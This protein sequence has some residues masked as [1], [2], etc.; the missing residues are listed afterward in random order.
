MRKK[1]LE[2]RDAAPDRPLYYTEW[3]ISSNPRDPQH[4]SS[5][6]AA[7]AVRIAMSVDDVVDGYSWW[8]FSDIFE[9]NYF[10]S[11]P[12]HGGF[13]MMNLY[14]IP[15]PIYRAFELVRRLGDQQFGV[16]G[17][18]ATVNVWVGQASA[19][20]GARTLVLIVNQ[21]MPRHPIAAEPVSVRLA[22][23]DGRQVRSAV[24][25]RVDEDHAN[26]A[27]AWA[28][29]GSPEYLKPADV[30]ALLAASEVS[31]EPAAFSVDAGTVAFEMTVAAQSVNLL[32]IEWANAQ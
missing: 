15:K 12:F 21:A 13:G 31:A 17:E 5:F 24:L 10:P 16:Q 20:P 3:S 4:D 18:H 27:R 23:G 6:A 19:E 14:G 22:H 2:A 7:L 8:T 25:T 30:A 32:H 26:P 9:E 11:V 29:M 1:A 28:A